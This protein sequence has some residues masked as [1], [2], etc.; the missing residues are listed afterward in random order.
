MKVLWLE[1]ISEYHGR[2]V[3]FPPVRCFPK[4][5]Q[6]PHPPI[7][8]GSVSSPHALKRVAEWGDGWLPVVSTVD[9]F[10]QGVTRIK[11]MAKEAGRDPDGFDFTVFA[12][13]PQWRTKPELKALERVGANRVVLWL[14]GPDLKSILKET[15]D[16][17]RTVLS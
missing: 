17:A 4:P 15:E 16:L 1:E 13:E 12:L 14:L 5:A 9:Q 10:A 11:E 2:Y 7:L 6:K 8:F 3:D